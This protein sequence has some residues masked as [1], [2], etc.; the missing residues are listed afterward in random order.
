MC[1]FVCIIQS[2]R[3]KEDY[4]ACRGLAHEDYEYVQNALKLINEANGLLSDGAG[5]GND[6][7]G[8]GEGVRATK[9]VNSRVASTIHL[10]PRNLK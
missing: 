2:G 3:S 5:N 8:A 1:Y 4:D 6:D 9:H 10:H 7:D